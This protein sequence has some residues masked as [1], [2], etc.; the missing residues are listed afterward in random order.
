M[1]RAA[2]P[3]HIGPAELLTA[4]VAGRRPSW[5]ATFSATQA[6]PLYSRLLRCE[7]VRRALAQQRSTRPTIHPPRHHAT[8]T[9]HLTPTAP[10]AT[11]AQPGSLPPQHGA[12]GSDARLAVLMYLAHRPMGASRETLAQVIGLSIDATSRVLTALRRDHRVAC[13]RWDRMP[14]WYVPCARAGRTGRPPHLLASA[15]GLADAGAKEGG[16]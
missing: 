6:H 5:P 3:L 11:A 14:M 2:A 12:P 10:V 8:P 7:A 16:A 9:M 15:R 13:E 4:W 1:A